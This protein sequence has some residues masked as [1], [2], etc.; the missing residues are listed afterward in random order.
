MK[1][2]GRSDEYFEVGVYGPKANVDYKLVNDQLAMIWFMEDDNQ[3]TIDSERHVFQKN[4]I[5]FLTAFNKVEAH[6]TSEHRHMI[7][8]K[9]FYCILDHDSEV[10][11]KGILF[12]GSSSFPILSPEEKDLDILN[13]VW[14]MLVIEMQSNDNLQLEMLQMMLKRILILAT[15]IYKATHSFNL[16]DNPQSDVVRNFNFLVEQHFKEK[17]SVTEYAQLLNKSPKTLSNIFSK[18]SDRSPLQFIQNR[19]ML[20]V[21][22]LLKYTDRPV[23]EIGYEVGFNDIQSFSRFFKKNQGVSPSEF[24]TK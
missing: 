12:Y 20:E 19:I 4:Q 3:W 7:F 11:C 14:K 9:P 24:R 8:N 13:T 10:G 23:S 15:R 2:T 17:H 1:F 18:L 22:R 5:I 6:T 21:K 16:I